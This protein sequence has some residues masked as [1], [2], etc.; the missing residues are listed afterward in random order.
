MLGLPWL[1]WVPLR[2]VRLPQLVSWLLGVPRLLGMRVRWLGLPWLL[3]LLVR[4]LQRGGSARL[5]RL[6]LRRQLIYCCYVVE[7]GEVGVSG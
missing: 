1:P 4:L 6:Q 3:W 5:L 7:I 2:L